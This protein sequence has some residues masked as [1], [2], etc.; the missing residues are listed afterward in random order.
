MAFY[1]GPQI[2]KDGLVLWLDAA[3]NKSYTSGSA[4]WRDM[5]GNNNSGSLING[6]TFSSANN[7]SIVFDGVND[8]INCG[9]NSTLNFGT[10]NFT[11]SVWFRRVTNIVTN[12][13]LLSKGG[14]SDLAGQAGFAFF[15]SDTSISFAVNPTGARTII[16]AAS[17]VV[18]EWV[19][20]VGLLERGVSM[21]SYKNG[22]LTA[23]EVPPIGSVS[24]TIDNLNLGR[25]QNVGLY[26]PG[27]I[28][29]VQI[30]N[31]ALT[32]SEVQQNFNALRGRYNL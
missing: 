2:V 6:P 28:S 18:G 3:N 7:G 24:N 27:S 8:Y 14:A 26:W 31:R 25:S 13:R 20:V 9:N 30:Y 22:T 5:S 17:Y 12:L 29:N 21:R 4:I 1:R 19:N 11:V 16:V 15:G 32:E 23:T 10:G